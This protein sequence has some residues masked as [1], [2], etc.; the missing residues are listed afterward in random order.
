MRIRCAMTRLESPSTCSMQ[1]WHKRRRAP[2]VCLRIIEQDRQ[3]RP[4]QCQHTARSSVRSVRFAGDV[5]KQSATQ[6]DSGSRR[7]GMVV[8]RSGLSRTCVLREY[9]AESC[10]VGRYEFVDRQ[11]HANAEH[12]GLA[13]L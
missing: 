10:T 9:G 4:S 1:L 8:P 3:T 11:H 5:Q 6:H 7:F 2:S 12:A 13:G